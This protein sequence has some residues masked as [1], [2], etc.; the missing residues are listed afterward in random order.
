M[1]LQCTFVYET[2]AAVI[3]VVHLLN[4]TEMGDEEYHYFKS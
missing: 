4:C 3:I 1:K 2:T